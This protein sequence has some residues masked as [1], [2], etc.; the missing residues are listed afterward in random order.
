MS[1]NAPNTAAYWIARGINPQSDF[2]TLSSS[3]VDIILDSAKECR[4]RKP[5]NAN[6][7]R[8]RYF[9]CAVQRKAFPAS[10]KGNW[11]WGNLS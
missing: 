3:Q 1:I 8:A 11:V 9:F 10:V 7:S 4:Y 5:K 6:G 2:H